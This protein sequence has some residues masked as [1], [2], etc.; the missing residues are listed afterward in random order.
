MGCGASKTTAHTSRVHI[1]GQC[2][3]EVTT[4][5][6]FLVIIWPTHGARNYIAFLIGP[7]ENVYKVAKMNFFSFRIGTNALRLQ[8]AIQ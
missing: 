1:N 7:I 8:M 4:L 5:L 6:S 2:I 3:P